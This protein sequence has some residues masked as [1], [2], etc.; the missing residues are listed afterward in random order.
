[1]KLVSLAS[2][3]F[4]ASIPLQMGEKILGDHKYGFIKWSEA[5]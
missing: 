4:T 1:V 5:K 2:K 3:L